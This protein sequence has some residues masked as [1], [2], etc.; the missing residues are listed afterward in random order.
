MEHWVAITIA[1]AFFQNIRF[2]LQKRLT[3]RLSTL[4]VTFARFVFAAPLA[5]AVAVGILWA[6]GLGWPRL[7]AEFLAYALAGAVAQIV[8]TALLVAL[9]SYR[10]FAVG[11]AFSKTETVMTVVLSAIVLGEWLG[12]WA[13]AA[14]AITIMGVVLMSG[15]PSRGEWARGLFSYASGIGIFSGII[16]AVASVGYRGAALALEEG[17]FLARGAVTL[18]FVTL[19]QTG[20]MAAWLAWRERGEIG[21]VVAAWPVTGLVGLFGMAGSLGWFTAFALVNAAAVKAVGQIE[22]L[23]TLLTSYFIFRE[24]IRPSELMGIALIL[25]GI[26]IIALAGLGG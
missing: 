24:R 2:L 21:R 16:F 3:S 13:L 19:V 7:S 8:A 5:L 22:L 10:N 17:D 15:L 4:G 26:L 12:P 1:A 11:I 18:A 20:M 6:Q 25:A 14:V 9:F 23:F